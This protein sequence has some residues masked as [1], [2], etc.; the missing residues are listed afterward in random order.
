MRA[1]VVH[2]SESLLGNKGFFVAVS[3]SQGGGI[4]I[5]VAVSEETT[6]LWH[7]SKA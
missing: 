7:V 1:L 3:R 2:A 5:L 6:V 4:R